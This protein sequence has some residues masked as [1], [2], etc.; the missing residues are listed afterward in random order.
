MWKILILLVLIGLVWYYYDLKFSKK[1]EQK[2][3]DKQIDN[4]EA[5]NKAK[6]LYNTEQKR[7]MGLF[8]LVQSVWKLPKFINDWINLFENINDIIDW[9]V[10]VNDNNYREFMKPQCVAFRQGILGGVNVSGCTNEI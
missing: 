8:R 10:Y 7:Q 2:R 6:E 5:I 4:A 9:D 1:A 3:I